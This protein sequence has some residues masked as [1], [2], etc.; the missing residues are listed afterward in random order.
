MIFLFRDNSGGSDEWLKIN[1]ESKE[2]AILK[3]LKNM[4]LKE[5]IDVDTICTNLDLELLNPNDL[6]E[7]E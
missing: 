2:E 4:L 3:A 6:R 5:T 7:Y 1:S